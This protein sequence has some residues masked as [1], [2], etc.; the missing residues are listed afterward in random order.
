ML[1]KVRNLGEAIELL[2]ASQNVCVESFLKRYTGVA[3]RKLA[4]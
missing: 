1:R 3:R 4:Q 2:A